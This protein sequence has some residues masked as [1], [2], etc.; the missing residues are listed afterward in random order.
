MNTDLSPPPSLRHPIVDDHH[1]CDPATSDGCPRC[2]FPGRTPCC[3]IHHPDEFS[4]F[5]P[6]EP[7]TAK[8]RRPQVPKKYKRPESAAALVSALRAWRIEKTAVTCGSAYL[9][10]YGASLVLPTDTLEKLVDLAFAGRISSL[11]NLLGATPWRKAPVYGQEV[12]DII[13]QHCPILS[14]ASNPQ[15]STDAALA[16]AVHGAYM[17]WSF[18]RY[19][20][21]FLLRH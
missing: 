1:L 10:D 12:L 2:S 6:D 7:K 16:P 14:P 11:E 3:D 9:S 20:T 21:L 8:S 15:A 18:V 4:C 19:L 13:R 5:T 17:S